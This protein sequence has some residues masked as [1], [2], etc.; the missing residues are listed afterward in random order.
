[1]PTVREE[2]AKNLLHHRKKCNLTQK[3]FAEKLG[4]KNSAVSNW[5]NGLN[6]IDIDTL[7]RACGVFGVT[8]NDM[9]GVF[10]NLQ[11]EDYQPQ[12]KQLIHNYRSLN[13]EGKEKIV[14][15]I[16]DIIQSGKHK[17]HNNV[18]NDFA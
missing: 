5:E 15:Y 12:E 4:V 6:S 9:Y 11:S 2:I 18:G 17:K 7:H 10:A 16:D 1:M 14:E 3:E 13:Q 8:V